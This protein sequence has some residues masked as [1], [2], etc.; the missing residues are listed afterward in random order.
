MGLIYHRLQAKI[1]VF[2]S[3]LFM[4]DDD[5]SEIGSKYNIHL[6]LSLIFDS[7]LKSRRS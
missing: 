5:G 2:S 7:N 4:S 3:V 6:V 1:P